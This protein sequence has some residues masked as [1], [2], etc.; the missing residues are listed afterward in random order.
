MREKREAPEVR[1]EALD[2]GSATV[3]PGLATQDLPQDQPD[4][5][6]LPVRQEGGQSGG[7]PLTTE[8]GSHRD[9]DAEVWSRSG[10]GPGLEPLSLQV[11]L[12]C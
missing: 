1:R 3:R 6:P 5:R 7:S 12:Y 8:H 10:A 9:E 11:C 2:W 4:T